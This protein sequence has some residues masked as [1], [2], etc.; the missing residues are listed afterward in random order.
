MKLAGSS[1]PADAG[2][3]ELGVGEGTPGPE[4]PQPGAGFRAWRPR[5]TALQDLKRLMPAQPPVERYRLPA[6]GV[7]VQRADDVVGKV[8]A[9]RPVLVERPANDVLVP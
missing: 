7:L 5:R 1:T 2:D 6:P 3:K 4:F 8:G 9:A